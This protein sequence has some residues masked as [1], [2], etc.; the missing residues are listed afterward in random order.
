MTQVYE[1]KNLFQAIDRACEDNEVGPGFLKINVIHPENGDVQVEV[2]EVFASDQSEN[3]YASHLDTVKECAQELLDGMGLDSQVAVGF[4]ESSILC[5]IQ[6]EAL[7]GLTE[8]RSDRLS[9]LQYVL[10]RYYQAKHQDG[11]FEIKC[12]IN[13]SRVAREKELIEMAKS[14]LARLKEPG[15]ET[16]LPPLNAYERRIVHVFFQE[17]DH[18]QTQ[19]EGHGH[20]KRIK[21]S[22][23]KAETE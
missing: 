8:D 7:S 1:G 20:A 11:I 5:D 15:D 4:N 19:S 17:N 3:L 18:V 22:W 21:L 10:M 14:A 23:P 6:S 12:D 13:G 2:L 9:D 16:L